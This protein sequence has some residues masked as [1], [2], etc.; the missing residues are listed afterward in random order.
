MPKKPLLCVE[1]S[2]EGILCEGRQLGQM[3]VLG[4]GSRPARTQIVIYLRIF[5]IRWCSEF[6][7]ARWLCG[8]HFC[9]FP[10]TYRGLHLGLLFQEIHVSAMTNFIVRAVTAEGLF[11]RLDCVHGMSWRM[12]RVGL[13]FEQVL[14]WHPW[15]KHAIDI[16]STDTKFLLQRQRMRYSKRKGKRITMRSL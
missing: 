2:E 7:G 5:C 13:E 1:V 14:C 11:L 4:S 12:V 9:L 16:S 6:C 8:F 15:N 3:A 10:Q